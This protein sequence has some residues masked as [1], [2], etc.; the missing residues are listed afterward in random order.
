MANGCITKSD[1]FGSFNVKSYIDKHVPLKII[2]DKDISISES[3]RGGVHLDSYNFKNTVSDTDFEL[4][5][6]LIYHAAEGEN[7][8]MTYWVNEPSR[9][10]FKIIPFVEDQLGPGKLVL[11][12]T[13]SV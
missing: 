6:S 1:I 4:G 7:A 12:V 9:L 8:I 3:K 2:F 10:P 5:R 11:K 13:I